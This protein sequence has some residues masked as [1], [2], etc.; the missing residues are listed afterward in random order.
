MIRREVI[1]A[2]LRERQDCKN[3]EL[4]AMIDRAI[5]LARDEVKAKSIYRIVDCVPAPDGRSVALDGR[6]FESP[7]LTGHLRSCQKAVL[8]AV[9]LGPAADRLVRR[10]G[11]SGMAPAAVM[12]AV[13]AE[14]TEEACDALEE[15]IMAKVRAL[16]PQA[17]F[18]Q[19]YSPGYSDFSLEYQRD[20]FALLDITKRIGVGLT[21]GLLMV[22][23]KTVTAVLGVRIE[24]GVD[25]PDMHTEAGADEPDI[26]TKAR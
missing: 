9:T 23:T 18:V 7:Y 6:R 19:R 20:M 14:M 12:Q 22:P 16:Y 25:E 4:H 17:G 8:L 3:E 10:A 21:T 2:Y 24:A 11:L 5:A 15:S 1:L 13:L 26:C